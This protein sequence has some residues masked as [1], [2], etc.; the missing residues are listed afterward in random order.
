MYHANTN[1]KIA[2]IAILISDRADFKMKIY[3][4]WKRALHSDREANS[5]Q[6]NMYVHNIRPLNHM[7]QKLIELPGKIDESTM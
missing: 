2:G 1:Q 6:F 7:R 5:Q 4:G 3:Q